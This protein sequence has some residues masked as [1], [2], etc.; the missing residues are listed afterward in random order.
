MDE[1]DQSFFM[2]LSA[3]FNMQST[4]CMRRAYSYKEEKK[5]AKNATESETRT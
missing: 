3:G 1:R 4:C 2:S 5:N